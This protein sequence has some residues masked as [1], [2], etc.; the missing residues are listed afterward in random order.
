MKWLEVIELRAVGSNRE[1]LESHLQKLMHHM[2]EEAGTQAINMYRRVMIDS[3]VSI[4]LVYD[5]DDVK[6]SGGPLSSLGLQLASGL[7]EF[8]LVN[9]SVWIEISAK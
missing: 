5:S 8:G 6:K 9:H 4:H 1:L 2:D 7:K 3:D